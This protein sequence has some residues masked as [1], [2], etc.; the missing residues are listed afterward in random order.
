M[1]TTIIPQSASVLA[2]L[3]NVIEQ[4]Q[5]YVQQSKAPNAW[6]AY[7]SDWRDFERWCATRDVPALPATLETVAL[8]LTELA[9]RCKVSTLQRRMSAI[10]QA[11]Q[12]QGVESPTRALAVRSVM[13]GV[14]RVK[15][16]AQH[17][18]AAAVTETIR[19]MVATLDT[20]PIGTRDRALL[21]VGFA[22]AFRRSELVG[23]DMEDVAFS[24][25]GM[26]IT[27][28]RS[29]TDQEGQGRKIR[30]TQRHAATHVPCEGA[31]GMDTGCWGCRW[32][33]VPIGQPAWADPSRSPQ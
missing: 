28:K 13:A 21:L 27:L 8:Y 32:P 31:Q 7:A 3:A 17:G 5:S 25:E 15:G 9:E 14:R 29:K 16:V 22:G 33:S 6:R 1:T 11:H 2:P 24:R 26:V 30:H 19:A 20:S 23:L 10:S 12:A 18:K 4:A